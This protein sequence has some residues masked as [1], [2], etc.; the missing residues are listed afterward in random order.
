MQLCGIVYHQS[1]L[2]VLELNYRAF[3]INFYFLRKSKTIF[4]FKTRFCYIQ[5]AVFTKLSS[6]VVCEAFFLGDEYI[7]YY[8]QGLTSPT[9]AAR[10]GTM[11]YLRVII[12]W[13]RVQM[14]NFQYEKSDLCG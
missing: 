4:G 8:I 5:I 11:V 1:I 10:E 9:T 13:E 2:N 12:I 6:G 3:C 14:L 7:V